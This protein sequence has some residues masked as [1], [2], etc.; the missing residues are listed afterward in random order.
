MQ[1]DSS[2]YCHPLRPLHGI[3]PYCLPLPAIAFHGAHESQEAT[4]AYG[5][6]REATVAHASQRETTGA[7]GSA[8][9]PTGCHGSQRELT[10]NFPGVVHLDWNAKALLTHALF[11]N[12]M[13]FCI[14][15][16]CA[17]LRRGAL[18][19]TALSTCS[20]AL[21]SQFQPDAPHV[22]TK[23]RLACTQIHCNVSML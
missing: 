23:L 9:E 21:L 18:R 7:H 16:C 4:G 22:S 8:R 6:Q 20:E 2:S 1:T 10:G 11:R 17:K 5:R 15:A 3:V 12:L 13:R 14:T 19:F